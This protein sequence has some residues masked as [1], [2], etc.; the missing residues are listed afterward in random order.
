MNNNKGQTALIVLLISTIVLTLGLSIG[1]RS[2]TNLKTDVNEE[3]KK[4]SFAMAESAIDYYLG[5]KETAYSSGADTAKLTINNIGN[6]NVISYGEATPI[7]ENINFWL[8]GHDPTTD[9]VDPTNY[10]MG[11]GVTIC[12]VDVG[13]TVKIDYYYS[14]SGTIKVNRSIDSMTLTNCKNLSVGDTPYL[15]SV[16]PLSANAKI[17]IVGSA[18]FPIQGKE[19]Q[20]NGVSGGGKETGA[21]SIVLV[22][23][24]FQIPTFLTDGM[25]AGGN[26]GP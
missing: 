4:K 7:G 15:V 14:Q 9:S 23:Q 26:I 12:P 25:A 8:V 5:T 17:K 3:T 2:V 19:I 11:S 21:K 16:M 22:N 18:N 13:V 10:F 1:R 20:A 24:I 6:T